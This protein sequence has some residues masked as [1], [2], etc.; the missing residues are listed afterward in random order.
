MCTVNGK[1][2]FVA[3]DQVF[4][5]ACLKLFFTLTKKKWFHAIFIHKNFLDGFFLLKLSA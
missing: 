5:F 4:P 2:K 3:P 1:S